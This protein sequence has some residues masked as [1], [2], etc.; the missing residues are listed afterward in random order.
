MF[1]P[2]SAMLTSKQFPSLF[3]IHMSIL[4]ELGVNKNWQDF[5]AKKTEKFRLS[6][7]EEAG[8]RLF[9]QDESYKPVTDNI[10]DDNF[11]FS[12]PEKK[13]LNKHGKGKKRVVYTFSECENNVLKLAAHLL[14]RYDEAQPHNCYSFR[15][16]YGAKKAIT[17]ITKVKDIEKKYSCKLDITDYFNSIDVNLLLPILY[18]LFFDDKDLY[19][20]F[21]KLLTADKAFFN[22]AVITEK[23]GAMA[24]TP[25][26]PFLANVY[27]AEMDRF[28][29]GKDV[30]YARYSDDII[31]FA[32]T[33]KSL[34]EYL[35]IVKDFLAEYH[36]KVNP[37]KV[38][39]TKPG[40]T[41]DY[42]GIAFNNFTI[43]LS[44]VTL[45][46]IKGK[47]RRKARAIYRWKIRKKADN[48]KA[49]V[50]FS[51][52]LNRKFFGAGN[53]DEFTWARWFFPLITTKSDLKKID[54][55]AQEYMRYLSSGRFNKANY[56]TRYSDLK[57]CGYRSLVHEYYRYRKS[58]SCPGIKN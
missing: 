5:L 12:V 52:S 25:V 22:G 44:D 6:K 50:V 16:H 8:L 17:T 21:E 55:Y 2:V 53:E 13:L 49:M 43:G 1:S 10:L 42:L 31:F 37:E 33:E 19:R 9:I 3:F 30:L 7:K 27:L 11:F 39:I 57:D 45:K 15:R 54:A 38:K 32:D 58:G 26:S 41:W 14:Y 51:R 48:R 29:L 46:K 20:F 34:A 4:K 36:L 40:E 24:G 56:R 23:R 35:E 47:I 28:F 18:K